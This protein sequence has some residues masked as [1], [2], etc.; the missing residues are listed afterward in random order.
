MTTKKLLVLG[1]GNILLMD[2][3]VGVYAVEELGKEDWPEDIDSLTAAL[4]RKIFSIFLK[5]MTMY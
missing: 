1:V 4:L 5:N 2:E 3:G